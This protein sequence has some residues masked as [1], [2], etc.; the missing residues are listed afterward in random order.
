MVADA[1]WMLLSNFMK[2]VGGFSGSAAK[3]VDFKNM[4]CPMA[5]FSMIVNTEYYMLAP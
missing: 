3:M 4:V 2:V 5:P 1:S